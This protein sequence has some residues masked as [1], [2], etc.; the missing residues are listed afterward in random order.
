MKAIARW[1]FIRTHKEELY[2][3]AVI[4]RSPTEPKDASN[5]LGILKAMET[6]DLFVR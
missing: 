1:L 4:L 6:L 5:R 3:L 2:S